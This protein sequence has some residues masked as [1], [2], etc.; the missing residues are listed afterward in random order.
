[1]PSMTDAQVREVEMKN[2]VSAPPMF[3]SGVDDGHRQLHPPGRRR[4][5][6]IPAKSLLE[7]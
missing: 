3:A 6:K 1:M 7:R 2:A 5:L 4:R